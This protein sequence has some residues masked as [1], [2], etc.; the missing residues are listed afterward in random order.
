MIDNKLAVTVFMTSTYQ[1]VVL[2]QFNSGGD[3]ISYEDLQAGTKLDDATLKPILAQ[4]VRAK[5]L[6][7][8][9]GTYDLNFGFKSK[10][11]RFP[12]TLPA[13]FCPGSD[14]YLSLCVVALGASEPQ[15]PH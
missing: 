5:V 7:Q 2:L 6:T 10:K 1:A 8:S 9:D 4:F 13:F 3:S 12:L 14:N 15:R 11:V